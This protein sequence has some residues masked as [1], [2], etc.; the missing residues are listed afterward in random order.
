MHRTYSI[1]LTLDWCEPN[2]NRYSGHLYNDDDDAAFLGLRG[3]E[4]LSVCFWCKTY[5]MILCCNSVRQSRSD[6]CD[7]SNIVEPVTVFTVFTRCT[8]EEA[9]GYLS[10]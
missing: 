2:S 8:I 6:L 1:H 7:D 9:R 4:S 3:A 5:G 10:N